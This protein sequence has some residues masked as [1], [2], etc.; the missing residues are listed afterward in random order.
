MQHKSHEVMGQPASSVLSFD[1]PLQN[2]SSPTLSTRLDLNESL[3]Q[4]DPCTAAG[5]AEVSDH[6]R[7][8]DSTSSA[9]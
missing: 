9:R 6:R 3:G 5:G 8:S 4:L 7:P 2:G 1:L